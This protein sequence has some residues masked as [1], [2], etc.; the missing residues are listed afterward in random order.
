[1]LFLSK[2]SSLSYTLIDGLLKYWPFANYIKEALFL[3][4]LLEVFEIADVDKLEPFLLKLIKRFSKS[5]SS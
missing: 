2:D 4:E 1:M 5:L 3:E